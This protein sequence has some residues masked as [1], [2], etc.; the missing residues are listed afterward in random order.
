M[1]IQYTLMVFITITHGLT[2]VE[3]E[4]TSKQENP[5]PT[6]FQPF[7]FYALNIGLLDMLST[8]EKGLLFQSSKT[9]CAEDPLLPLQCCIILNSTHLY[10]HCFHKF[11]TILGEH[12]NN[13]NPGYLYLA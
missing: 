2:A 12:T 13:K 6:I 10:F 11:R 1:N 5:R 3:T 7:A 8:K 4:T 9:P